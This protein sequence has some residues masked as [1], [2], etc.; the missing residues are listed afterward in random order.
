MRVVGLTGGI[1]T[2][3]TTVARMLASHGL[4]VI[5]ADELAREVVAPGKPAWHEVVSAFGRQIL[6]EDTSLNR[7]RLREIVLQDPAAR[8]RL[9]DLIH[10]RVRREVKRRLSELSTAGCEVAVVE[11]PL[12]FEAGWADL[13]HVIVAITAPEE[14]C[15]QRLVERHRVSREVARLWIESQ[16]PQE[17]KARRASWAIANDKDLEGL[18]TQVEGLVRTLEKEILA[19]NLGS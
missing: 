19:S 17:E 2:G 10:P 8:R 16:M 14:V 12:L 11:V 7:A 5:D 9:E 18:K 1:A 4:P 13:F 3:K 6:N 15:V